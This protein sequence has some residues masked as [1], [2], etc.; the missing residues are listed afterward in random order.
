MNYT[1]Y[2]R[3]GTTF[4]WSTSSDL[5]D[6]TWQSRTKYEP[7]QKGHKLGP[8]LLQWAQLSNW[9]GYFS[10][11]AGLQIHH[12]DFIHFFRREMTEIESFSTKHSNNNCSGITIYFCDD[13]PIS[14]KELARDLVRLVFGFKFFCRRFFQAVKVQR[15]NRRRRLQWGLQKQCWWAYQVRSKLVWV[16]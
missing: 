12:L 1:L 9:P 14:T 6:W 4:N 13:I 16:F 11:F 5:V 7:S 15:R 8:N 10:I 2:Q 3:E